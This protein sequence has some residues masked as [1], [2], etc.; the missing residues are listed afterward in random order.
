MTAAARTVPSVYHPSVDRILIRHLG[1]PAAV[2]SLRRD[3]EAAETDLLSRLVHQAAL[4]LAELS[5]QLTRAIRHTQTDLEAAT[6]ELADGRCAEPL[7]TG[8][9]DQ[10]A[11]LAHRHRDALD[12]IEPL[13]QL[14]T[15]SRTGDGEPAR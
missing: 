10:I 6:V 15:T 5:L 3:A 9:S 2:A 1:T 7:L 11:I 12:R 13:A 14:W 8:R 4:K